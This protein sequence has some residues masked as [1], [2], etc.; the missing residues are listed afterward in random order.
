M[1]RGANLNVSAQAREAKVSRRAAKR[2]MIFGMTPPVK[3]GQKWRA[4]KKANERD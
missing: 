4:R 3:F 2:G 1:G